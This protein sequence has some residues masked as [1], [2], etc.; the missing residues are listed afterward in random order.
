MMQLSRAE[1]RPCE[2][3]AHTCKYLPELDKP[4]ELSDMET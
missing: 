1:T 4:L 2:K 3:R